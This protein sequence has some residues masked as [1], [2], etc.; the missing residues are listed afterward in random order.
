MLDEGMSAEI[1]RLGP[2]QVVKSRGGS[3]LVKQA[4]SGLIL[5]GSRSSQAVAMSGGSE[6]ERPGSTNGAPVWETGPSQHDFQRQRGDTI[7]L[8]AAEL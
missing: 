7:S 6:M 5:L 2:A 3:S 4:S 8:V 1:A